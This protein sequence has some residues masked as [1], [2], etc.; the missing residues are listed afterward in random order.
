MSTI[1]FRPQRINRYRTS[2]DH[3]ASSDK[4]SRG[5]RVTSPT[6]R[7]FIV[8]AYLV[9]RLRKCYEGVNTL[10]AGI[11]SLHMSAILASIFHST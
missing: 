6:S 1:L 10:G 9:Y 7:S 2:G 8:D 5:D 3:F 11:G 4:T